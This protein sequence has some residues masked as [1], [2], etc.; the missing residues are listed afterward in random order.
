MCA[1]E[2]GSIG[3][4]LCPCEAEA[5]QVESGIERRGSFPVV[6]IPPGG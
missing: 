6:R 3:A 2:K 4:H 1:V 5:E